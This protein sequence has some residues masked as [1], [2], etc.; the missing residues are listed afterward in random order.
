MDGNIKKRM[1]EDNPN[2][3]IEQALLCQANEA[4]ESWRIFK[5]MAEFVSGFELL[6]RYGKA[7]T[8]LGSSRCSIGDKVYQQAIDLG[9]KLSR[10]GFTIITGGGGGVMEA[11]NRG[12]YEAGGPS[13]GLNIQLPQEQVLNKYVTDAQGFHY[14]FTRKVMLAFA[15]EVYVFFP[16]GFGTLD[17]FFELVTLVQTKKVQPLPLILVGRD[18]WEPL[19]KWIEKSVFEVWQAIDKEDTRI[20]HV[21]DSV[22]EAYENVLRLSQEF[23]K[24]RAEICAVE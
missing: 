2:R 3:R 19:T 4:M 21:V 15:A 23:E 22:D 8:I 13:I 14:F 24:H 11:A 10:A 9:G 18:Y 5:I 16:G 20:Y 17:E 6:R 12:A 1:P 7:V